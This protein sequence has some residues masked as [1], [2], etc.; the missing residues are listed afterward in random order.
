MLKSALKMLAK[1]LAYLKK[2]KGATLVEY[3]IIITVICLVIT[4]SLK[5]TSKGIS[6]TLNSV[7]NYI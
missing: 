6:N 1:K 2:T 5:F 3:G 7:S 4:A